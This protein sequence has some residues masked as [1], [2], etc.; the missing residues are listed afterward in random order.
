MGRSVLLFAVLSDE[1]KR[2]MYDAG[3][4]DLFDEDE[5]SK[6]SVVF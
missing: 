3:V 1:S 4:L 6:Y 2:S 5:V